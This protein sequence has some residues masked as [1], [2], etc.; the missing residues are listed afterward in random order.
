MTDPGRARPGRRIAAG[1]AAAI[2]LVTVAVFL[3]VA[4]HPFSLFDDDIYITQNEAVREGLSPAGAAWAFSTFHAA[5]WHPLTWMSHML[6]VDLF[7]L[8]PAGHHLVGVA[9]HALNGALLFLVLRAMT[10][11][12][13]PCAFA[14]LLF[15]LHPLRVES[16]AWASERKDLLSTFFG[17]LAMAAYRRYAAAPRLPGMLAVCLL[18]ACSLM[19]KSML[20]TLPFLFLVLDGWPL[21]RFGPGGPGPARLLREKLPLFLLSGASSAVTL[22]AQ[23]TGQA[24][25]G[26]GMLTIPRR[27]AGA[28]VAYAGYL[29]KAAWPAGLVVHYP[30]AAD[31]PSPW[32]AAGAALLLAAVTAAAV[33]LRKGRPW[34]LAGW[35]WYLGTLVP[36]IGLVQV[37]VQSM[38]DRYSYFPLCG[39]FLAVA[40]EG[41]AWVG[42]APVRE[43]VATVA[44]TLALA[45]L[46]AVTHRQIGY[47]ATDVSLF[48]HAVDETSGNWKAHYNLGFALLAEGNNAEAE[49]Q[50]RATLAIW[51]EYSNA[52]LNLGTALAR[53][54]RF[55]EA[56]AQFR[57]TL[58]LAPDDPKAARNLAT[59]LDLIEGSGGGEPK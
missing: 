32:M 48:R 19:S 22:L 21:G 5:N 51:P 52:H 25:V 15:A 58:R 57:E 46:V 45:A 17:L 38:A 24:V 26:I 2:V 39:I 41:R 6:D 28:L 40:F 4:R 36:V 33:R 43:R 13:W 8:D 35:L 12:T 1:I 11:A 34:L 49:R 29:A 10:G 55:P 50:F 16:V 9:F 59:A 30:I 42:R 37:G 7:G 20:V 31:G 53:Q 44:A 3:P 56:V 18:F 47:W 27:I 14:A 54:N 23:S